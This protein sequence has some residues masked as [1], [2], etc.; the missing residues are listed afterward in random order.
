MVQASSGRRSEYVRSTKIASTQRPRVFS[1]AFAYPVGEVESVSSSRGIGRYDGERCNNILTSLR[2]ICKPHL[3]RISVFLASV[4]LA[5][6]TGIVL[7][8]FSIYSNIIFRRDGMTNS[9][10]TTNK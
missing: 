9:T 2:L 10:E 1:G 3:H 8:F 5:E 6:T 7:S 4:F